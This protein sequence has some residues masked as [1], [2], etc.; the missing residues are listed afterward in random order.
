MPR[1]ISKKDIAFIQSINKELIND[2]IETLV[3]IFK[4]AAGE[5]KSNIYGESSRKVFYTGVEVSCLIER[6][7]GVAVSYG[8][9][10][11]RTQ[12]AK[13]RFLRSTLE[14]KQIYPEIGDFIKFNDGYYEI[15]NAEEEQLVGGQSANKHSIIC[16]AHLTR[17][18]VLNIEERIV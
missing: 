8:F 15:H 9:G 12:A 3:V 1:F 14:E 11:D 13:F 6:E 4:V 10:T 2:V 16:G 5:T 7:E 18:T 17:K